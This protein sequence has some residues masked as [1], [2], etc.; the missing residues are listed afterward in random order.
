M[1][2]STIKSCITPFKI[3]LTFI[4]ATNSLLVFFSAKS[5]DSN[6]KKLIPPCDVNLL[7]P[8]TVGKKSSLTIFF[9]L[10][11]VAGIIK[12]NLAITNAGLAPLVSTPAFL[13]RASIFFVSI[14]VS[15]ES[16]LN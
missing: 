10:N 13:I 4:S 15:K 11:V 3:E 14:A 16:S 9:P 8:N 7:S 12:L 2:L 6:V 5:I 1:V